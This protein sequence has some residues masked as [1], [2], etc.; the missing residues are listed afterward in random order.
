[1]SVGATILAPLAGCV[2]PLSDVPDPV[3]SQGIVG[4]GVAI[5]PDG[6]GDVDVVAPISGRIAKIHPHAF[7]LS[8]EGVNVLVHLG[9][10]TVTLE[11]D[12]FAMHAQTG[13]QV[14]AGQRLITW[15][16]RDVEERGLSATCPVI[17][18]ETSLA[19]TYR[20]H[21]GDEVSAGAPLADAATA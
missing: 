18:M 21:E 8:A 12:G 10:D 7:V 3:F 17:F 20:A 1:M 15:H 6:E 9:I 16:P 11:G 2:H 13:E 19:I 5:V 14:E 4:P